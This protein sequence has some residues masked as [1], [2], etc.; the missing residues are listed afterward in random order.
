MQ[1]NAPTTAHCSY[2]NY[3]YGN[4]VRLRPFARASAAPVGAAGA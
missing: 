4:D 1:S 2:G 3:W